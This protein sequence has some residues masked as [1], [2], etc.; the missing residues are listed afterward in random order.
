MQVRFWVHLK[1]FIATGMCTMCL[2][3]GGPTFP[4]SSFNVMYKLS[5][6]RKNVF[7]CS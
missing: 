6:F 3:M 1:D 7:D 5:N 4:L 2:N